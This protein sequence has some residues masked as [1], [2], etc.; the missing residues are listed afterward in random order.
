MQIWQSGKIKNL[1]SN[2][3]TNKYNEI[4]EFSE[5]GNINLLLIFVQCKI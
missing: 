3:N 4:E 2:T 5:F 1:K